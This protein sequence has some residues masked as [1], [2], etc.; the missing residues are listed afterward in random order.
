MLHLDLDSFFVSVERLLN[1]DLNGKPVAVGGQSNRGVVASCSY[2]ARAF[3]VRSAMPM[4]K[5]RQLCK[6]LIV[7]GSG[8][9]NYSHYS[10]L[11]TDIIANEA[12]SFQKA[13]IDE[14]YVDLTGMDKYFGA[15]EW[16]SELRQQIIKETQLPISFGLGANKM[17]AKIASAQ[18]KPN[19]QL[20]IKHG[21]EQTF[22]AP[23]NIRVIPGLGAK[24]CAYLNKYGY[25]FIRDL[26]NSSENR[27]IQLCGNNGRILWLKA[28]GLHDTPLTEYSERKSI[29]TERTFF[30][31]VA[32]PVKLKKVL[33]QMTEKL[34]Y[35]LRTKD[36]LV[37]CVAIKIRYPNFETITRQTTINPSASDHEIIPAIMTLFE[38]Y[39]DPKKAIRLIGVRLSHFVSPEQQLSLFIDEDKNRKLYKAIDLLKNKFGDDT[40][41][42]G[43]SL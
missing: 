23:L 27:L 16:A 7:V 4:A 36:R 29:S 14:F 6:K 15:Y 33:T 41:K 17:M 3:G 21:E 37:A 35:K 13:S 9:A 25:H 24:S 22:L 8:R 19:G 5:A 32:D 39:F 40:I 18:A 26:Q 30:K 2:E 28:N 34:T 43:G 38:Q 12:P 42:R 20:W 1:P 31:D 10:R 11:V